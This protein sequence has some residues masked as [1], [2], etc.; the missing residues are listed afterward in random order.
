MRMAPGPNG[1]DGHC[2]L[3]HADSYDDRYR[4]SLLYY[5]H[6]VPRA[7]RGGDLEFYDV[8]TASPKGHS[9]ETLATI[10]QEDNLLI[11]FSSQTFHGITDVRCDSDDFAD[12]RFAAIAFLGVQGTQ[13]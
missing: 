9:D 5:F 1:L 2:G 7:F 12:G 8:D 13:Y 4:I 3:P 6:R 11:A 10:V